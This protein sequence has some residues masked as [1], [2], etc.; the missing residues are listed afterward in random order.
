MRDHATPRR[1]LALFLPYLSTDR[2]ARQRGRDDAGR[3]RV[4]VASQHGGMRLIA[5]DRR[6]EALGLTPGLPLADARAF[7]GPAASALEIAMADPA[8]DAACL[9]GLA[10]WCGRYA[11]WT[12]SD[13][14][15]GVWLDVTGSDHLF[16]GERRLAGDLAARLSRLGFVARAA[17]ADTAGA[18]WALARHGAADIMVVPSSLETTRAALAPLP[19]AALRLPPAAVETLERL[20]LRSVE[21][22][23]ALPREGLAARFGD[24]ARLRLDQAL[25]AIAEPIS[26]RRPV[27]PWRARLAFAEAIGTAEDL[28]R[29]VERLLADLLARL[30]ANHLGARR[31]ALAFYRVDGEIAEAAIGASRPTRDAR[32][33]ARL[34]APHLE[35]V[36]PGFGIEAATLDA[37]MVEPLSPTQLGFGP[38]WTGADDDAVDLAP[39]IDRL[40]NRLGP[41]AVFR[42]ALRESH[43][44]ERATR[45][46]RATDAAPDP[47]RNAGEASARWSEAR[48][49]LRLLR[50]PEPI[51]ATAPVP[52]DPPILFRWRGCVHRVLRADGPERLSPEWWQLFG[53]PAASRT[54]RMNPRDYY[55]VEDN[56]GRRF[57]VYRDGLFRNDAPPPRWFLHGVF[58]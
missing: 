18:A 5:V 30:A 31:L 44:P 34:F 50:H 29:V 4:V 14:A 15:D 47:T 10:A 57:W 55:R 17:I 37:M 41:D 32:A 20:G 56:A 3:P 39:L 52:D 16:G 54:R 12:A 40:A 6:A 58:A 43:I 25:G 9:D 27:A 19:V 23:Y 22:L 24:L 46:V 48:R 45:R 38:T 28:A 7:L 26:P 2:L 11:P 8:A 53:V 1:I 42:L 33:L 13:G 49:P 21:T 36:D 35:T 51:E